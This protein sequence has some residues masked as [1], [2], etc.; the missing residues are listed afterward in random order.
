VFANDLRQFRY[1]LKLPDDGLCKPKHVAATIVI[2]KVFNSLT[3]QNN[4]FA[5]VGQIKNLRY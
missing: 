1:I 3:I 4:L 2:L 5:L